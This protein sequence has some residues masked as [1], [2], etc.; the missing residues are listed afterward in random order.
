MYVLN[1]QEF[2]DSI[3]LRYGWRIPNTPAYC[4]CGK[5]ND[6]DHTLSCPNGGYTIMRHNCVRDLEGE[7]MKEVCRDVKIEPD[8][9]P[10]SE[11]EKV[12]KA[13]LD[14]SGVGVWGTHERTFLDV[15]IF[16]PN[17]PSYANME[18]EK[19]YVLHENTK[20]RKYKERVLNVE[21]GT[22]TPVVFSTTG[23]AGP[24][25]NSHHKRIAQLISTKRK[26]DYSCV[27]NYIRTRLR[28]NLLRS[29]LIAVRGERGKRIK[30]DP[31][32]E[33][34]FGMVPKL[35]D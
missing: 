22:L 26:E 23:G 25:A 20:K 35:K 14:V 2:R 21:H 32:S 28:F 11:Q 13:R 16:H 29:I 9:I 31:I 19:A 12:D 18:M 8:L 30:P 5:K 24:E 4:Q 3:C 10:V 34:E 7:L 27:I 1:K 17:C 33:I 15:K 6:I